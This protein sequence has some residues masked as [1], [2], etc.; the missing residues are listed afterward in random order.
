MEIAPARMRARMRLVMTAEAVS[1]IRCQRG[2]KRRS[3]MSAAT[4]PCSVTSAPM[5]RNVIQMSMSSGSLR[6]QSPVDCP[7]LRA[8]IVTSVI[9]NE[10][11]RITLTAATSA[12]AI[13]RR[14][15]GGPPCSTRSIGA[16]LL[17]GEDRV[18]HVLAELGAHV[19]VGLGERGAECLD[20]LR[21]LRRV[22][23][24]PAALLHRR[25]ELVRLGPDLLV[26]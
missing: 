10:A 26:V 14:T 4:W 3:T 8:K 18:D 11:S 19:V 25:D 22:A 16:A 12:L 6:L 24:L 17:R 21:V 20:R 15:A 7:R 9:T 5:P 2:E 23:H 13:Q 1:A